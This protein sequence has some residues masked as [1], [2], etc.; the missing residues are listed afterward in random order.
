VRLSRQWDYLL[1]ARI[2]GN[3]FVRSHFPAWRARCLLVVNVQ[4][5]LNCASGAHPLARG[6]GDAST[7]LI[8]DEVADRDQSSSFGLSHWSRGIRRRLLG[9]ETFQQ[10]SRFLIGADCGDLQDRSAVT[11]FD[12]ALV[13]AHS[14]APGGLGIWQRM[15]IKRVGLVQGAALVDETIEQAIAGLVPPTNADQASCKT[16]R[17][18]E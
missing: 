7:V 8:S 12:E 11:G 4:P 18:R 2:I 15:K 1:Y 3:G 14:S 5:Q 10:S 13:V 9:R 16:K 6:L 17:A